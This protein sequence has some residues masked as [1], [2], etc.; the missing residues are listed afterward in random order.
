MNK[1]QR[2]AYIKQLAATRN[3]GVRLFAV[4]N[5]DKSD[6]KEEVT[7]VSRAKDDSSVVDEEISGF[8]SRLSFDQATG[9]E[10]EVHFLL[11]RSEKAIVQREVDG[12]RWSMGRDRN[13][14]LALV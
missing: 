3:M 2:L 5:P 10:S 14:W 13:S 4:F 9:S 8:K 6:V 11:S 12:Y 7:L 1:T